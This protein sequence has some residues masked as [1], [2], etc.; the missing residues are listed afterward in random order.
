MVIDVKRDFHTIG[1][2]STRRGWLNPHRHDFS[3]RTKLIHA[4]FKFH[5]VR[6]VLQQKEDVLAACSVPDCTQ[7]V[8]ATLPLN[9]S[10]YKVL[11]D[12]NGAAHIG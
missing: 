7:V 2:L 3:S 6:C 4:A 9:G 5:G 8:L 12:D 11:H 10:Y 1:H